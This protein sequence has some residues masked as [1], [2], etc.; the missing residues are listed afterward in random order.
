VR[1]FGVDWGAAAPALG[2][3]REQPEDPFVSEL[4]DPLDV[5]L[6]HELLNR[7]EVDRF[8]TECVHPDYEFHTNVQ[9][10]SIPSVVHGRDELRAWIRQWY[11]DPWEGQRELNETQVP[12]GARSTRSSRLLRWRSKNLAATAP[13]EEMA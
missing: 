4:L 2:A 13:V 5:H 11:Q 12:G 3:Q 10:P 8:L 7:G 9:V 6:K 1:V